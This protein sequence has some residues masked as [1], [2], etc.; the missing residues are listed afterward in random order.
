MPFS[1]DQLR[2]VVVPS[3]PA[4]WGDRVVYVLRRADREGRKY[5]TSLWAVGLDGGEPVRLTR[6]EHADRQPIAAGRMLLFVSDRERGDQLWRLDAAGGEAGRLTSFGPGSLG[7]A[8]VSADGR[9]VIIVFT[10]ARTGP[11]PLATERAAR[12]AGEDGPASFPGVSGDEPA[13]TEPEAIPV[14]RVY[15]RRM[16]RLDGEGWFGDFLP[17]LW[18]VDVATGAARRVAGGPFAWG[19]PALSP[20]GTFV[21]APRAPVPAGD[22]EPTRN[23]LARVELATGAITV[24]P[25]PDGL[26]DAPSMSPDGRKVAFIQS[27]AADLWGSGNPRV[28]VHDLGAGNT[29]V[30]AADLDRPVGDVGLD[31][32]SAAPFLP[33]APCWEGDG[34]VVVASDRGATRLLRVDAG[35]HRWLTAEDEAFS[36]P[37]VWGDGR[38]VGL[39]GAPDA[40]LEVAVLDGAVRRL[41]GHNRALQVETEPRMPEMVRLEVDGVTVR[42]W[43]LA[44]RG[45]TGPAPGLL[46]IHGGPHAAYGAR[47]FFEM[48]W[49]ADQGFAVTWTNPRGS[50]GFGEAYCASVDPHWG[51]VDGRDQL[52]FVEAM[53]ARPEVDGARIGVTGGSYGGFMACF[54]A[55]TTD[56][57]A[58]A[59]ADRGL[60]DWGLDVAGGDYGHAVQQ[61]FGFDSPWRDPM[62]WQPY[63]LLRIA[64]QIR[65]PFLVLHGEGDLRCDRTQALALYQVLREAGTPTALLLFPEEDHGM[66]RKGRLDRR[67][68][69]LRQVGAWFGR[70]LGRSQGT[71]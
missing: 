24:L 35:G 22:V 71:R 48:H 28:L 44:P 41:T 62:P 58:A 67:Q 23:E 65:C 59:A 36:S 70:Y 42:G 5:R 33:W 57:F 20:D 69:R 29:T 9:T 55:A 8:A 43:Y 11:P 3:S 7:P 47:L 31:D 64:H 54:L 27:E 19:M 15:G 38:I 17:Q 53:A 25:R 40:F 12:P 61:L 39:H 37:V 30:L 50:H 1:L 63:S 2:H 32:L 52:A 21:V 4:R 56:R 34:L 68:E 46:Y 16:L 49:L 18:V 10:P 66:T 14:V 45:A 13:W 60:Y 26:A 51:H 6:G